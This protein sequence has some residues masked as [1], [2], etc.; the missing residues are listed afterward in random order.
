MSIDPRRLLDLTEQVDQLHNESMRTFREEAEE[1]HFGRSGAERRL[2]RRGLLSKAGAGGALLTV[3]AMASPVARFMPAAFAANGVDDA[4][5]AAFA[6]S[7]EFAAVAVYQEVIDRGRLERTVTKMAVTFQGHHREHGRAFNAI[8]K[9]TSEQ[10]NAKLLAAYKPRIIAAKAQD[11]LLEIAYS[12]EEAAAATYLFALGELQDK[13]NAMTA[14]TILP[15]ESQHAVVLA[16]VLD[17]K[18]AD[19]LPPFQN[20]KRAVDADQYPA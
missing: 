3:G 16:Q 4:A 2:S 14:A 13:T 1:I 6:A 11:A 5:I 17:K 10:P 20:D 9:A 19:Y 15:V 12:L 18:I 7:V 8:T